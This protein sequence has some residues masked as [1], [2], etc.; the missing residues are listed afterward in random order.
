M[1][2]FTH[3]ISPFHP[4]SSVANGAFEKRLVERLKKR[5]WGELEGKTKRTIRVVPDVRQFNIKLLAV[6]LQGSDF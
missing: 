5:I 1:W 3:L 6:G 2:L 4:N